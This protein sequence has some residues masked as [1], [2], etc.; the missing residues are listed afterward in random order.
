[1]ADEEPTEIEAL[2][3]RAAALER[4]KDHAVTAL[5]QSW[6][7]IAHLRG[8]VARSFEEGFRARAPEAEEPWLIDWLGSDAKRELEA[9]LPRP[10]GGPRTVA[11]NDDR[12]D[13][14]ADGEGDG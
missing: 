4:E 1:M 10:R 5:Q 9:L 6:R 7:L 11:A 8:L 14:G 3:A 12:P 13:G 2:A